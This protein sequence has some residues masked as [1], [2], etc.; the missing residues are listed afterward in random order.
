MNPTPQQI[1]AI[2]T[3]VAGLAGQW[4]KT[5]AE[6]RAAMQTT[7]VNNPL[8]TVP[9][10]PKPFKPADVLGALSDASKTNLKAFTGLGSLLDDIH[11]QNIERCQVWAGFLAQTGIITAAERTAVLAVVNATRNDPTW[12]VQVSW[13]IATL[14]RPA[15]DFDIEAGRAS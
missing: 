10:I 1:Q 13:D 2:K 6:I 7:L 15:D 11:A 9:V 4:S 3:F 5:D 14:G 8:T 12:S